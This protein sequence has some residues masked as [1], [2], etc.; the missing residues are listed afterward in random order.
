MRGYNLLSELA[1][2]KRKKRITTERYNVCISE[3]TIF[4]DL[5]FVFE[6]I[7]GYKNLY[8]KIFEDMSKFDFLNTSSVTDNQ[9]NLAQYGNI[10]LYDHTLN[11][12][13]QMV[14]ITNES[15]NHDIQMQKDIF[16]IIA[17]LH[18]SGKSHKLCAFYDIPLDEGH[19]IRSAYYFKKIVS[20]DDVDL[21]EIDEVAFDIIYNTLYLH[22]QPELQKTTEDSIFLAF[23]KKADSMA[24]AVEKKALMGVA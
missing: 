16:L 10:K 6:N 18:D 22:H 20:M 3:D 23:L 21:F 7:D 2:I 12:F 14:S 1:K 17:L 24:R 8:L 9:N 19:H 5:S 4:Q 13:K 15:N 11:T